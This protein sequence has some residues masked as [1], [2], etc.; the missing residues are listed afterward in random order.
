MHT[1]YVPPMQFD[2]D[3]A[4][5]TGDEH[6]HLRNVRRVRQGENIRM[7]DGKGTVYI[8]KVLDTATADATQAEILSA[9]FHNPRLPSLT[10]FQGVPKH[11]K[12]ELI[13]QKTTE[14]GVTQIIPMHSERSLQKPS[15]QR[16]ERW[17]RVVVS[18]T[19][20][21]KRA[22]LPELSSPQQFETCLAQVKRFTRSLICCESVTEQHIK[23]VLRHGES[24]MTGPTIVPTIGLATERYLALRE[25]REGQAPNSLDSP[26]PETIS[27]FIGP[28][29]GFAVEEVNAA[30]ENGCI[31]VTLGQNIL[32]TETAAIAAVAAVA[33]EFPDQTLNN[34]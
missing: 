27:I 6:H 3:I 23:T 31:P 4:T 13:L 24:A 28:E 25:K 12:M 30:I 17:Q 19:K 29:G 18:A 15:Q 21:C 22:W 32:R 1:S 9:E 34:R 8:A 10:L 26:K 2:G 16:C 14:L 7:I 20:Q 33:Y 5:M 11:D